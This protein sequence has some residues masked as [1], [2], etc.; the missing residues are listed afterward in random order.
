MR[1]VPAGWIR[2]GTE[3]TGNV[4]R[5]ASCAL[6]AGV[7][8]A[9][10]GTERFPTMHTSQAMKEPIRMSTRSPVPRILRRGAPLALVALIAVGV[11]SA[12]LR[13]EPLPDERWWLELPAPASPRDGENPWQPLLDRWPTATALAL[14]LGVVVDELSIAASDLQQ[15]PERD[16][17]YRTRAEAAAALERMEGSAA[18]HGARDEALRLF[19]ELGERG[20][21]TVRGGTTWPASLDDDPAWDLHLLCEWICIRAW[22]AGDTEAAPIALPIL[23]YHALDRTMSSPP[24]RHPH[25]ASAIDIGRLSSSLWLLEACVG[26]G[27]LDAE[28]DEWAVRLAAL[29]SGERLWELQV[30]ESYRAGR[31][32]MTEPAAR[33]E[34]FGIWNQYGV[35]PEFPSA[36]GAKR[37][38]L[39]LKPNRALRRAGEY[40]RECLRVPRRPAGTLPPVEP[41]SRLARIVSDPYGDLLVEHLVTWL[42]VAWKHLGQ[43]EEARDAAEILVAIRRHL[44]DRGALPE[45][46][47]AL[48]P[49]YFAALPVQPVD[50][51]PWRYDSARGRFWCGADPPDA[52]ARNGPWYRPSEGV[53]QA[54]PDPAEGSRER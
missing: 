50:G 5:S 47:D 26:L 6:R 11:W 4:K 43:Y 53:H 27:L 54:V 46:L 3:P 31:S 8:A 17:A 45:S 24:V 38:P 44:R 12:V 20:V 13:D 10:Q 21:L 23:L 49:E 32:A 41:D 7:G 33:R 15:D 42:P 51:G 48:V 25:G 29:P 40:C 9:S 37:D 2:R 18:D 30:R 22:A 1:A 28:L 39:R 34:F 35:A 19:L 52:R 36:T 14:D 16:M